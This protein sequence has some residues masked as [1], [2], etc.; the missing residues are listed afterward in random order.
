MQNADSVHDATQGSTLPP[1]LSVRDNGGRS[2][3]HD[4]ASEKAVEIGIRLQDILGTSD[5]AN[6]LKNNVIGLDVA[7]RVLLRPELR[8]KS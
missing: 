7:L 3:R 4:L 8:R 5:A 6:F 2:M 1:D